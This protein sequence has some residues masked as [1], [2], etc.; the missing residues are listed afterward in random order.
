[1]CG[2]TQ[3][4]AGNLRKRMRDMRKKNKSEKTGFDW[5]FSVRNSVRD[6]IRHTKLGCPGR[7]NMAL[8]RECFFITFRISQ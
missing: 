4:E 5:Q 1:M 6:C 8:G 7:T 3:I 2:D